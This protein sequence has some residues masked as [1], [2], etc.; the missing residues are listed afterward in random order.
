MDVDAGL[1]VQM[2]RCHESQ[3]ETQGQ[4]AMETFDEDFVYGMDMPRHKK[5]RKKNCEERTQNGLLPNF[6]SVSMLNGYCSAPK[7]TPISS[8]RHVN[9]P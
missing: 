9:F 2:N 7:I 1:D 4:Q 3:P 5:E 8:D 6:L